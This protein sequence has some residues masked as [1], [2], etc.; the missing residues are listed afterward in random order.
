MQF[1]QSRFS[2]SRYS[3]DLGLAGVI[4]TQLWHHLYCGGGLASV[5][6]ATSASYF[7]YLAAMVAVSLW[8]QLVSHERRRYVIGLVAIQVPV[9]GLAALL[10][11][12][13]GGPSAEA[14]ATR[15]LP[16]GRCDEAVATRRCRSARCSVG[17]HHE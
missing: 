10:E 6:M 5:A 1:S 2:L 4:S 8:P 15:P 17:S 11:F 12:F 13:T 14:V 9:V 3:L 7:V 16:R